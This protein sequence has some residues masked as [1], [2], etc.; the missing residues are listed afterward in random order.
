MYVSVLE[1]KKGG[2]YVIFYM[3]EKIVVYILVF[4]N[5]MKIKILNY[6]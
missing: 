2:G 5:F 1:D 4:I 3:C 6:Y